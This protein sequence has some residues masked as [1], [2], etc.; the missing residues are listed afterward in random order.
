MTRKEGS[1]LTSINEIKEKYEPEIMEIPGVTGIGIG[2]N[3]PKTGLAIKVYVERI[4]PDLRVQIPA[5]L[6]GYPVI[7]EETGELGAF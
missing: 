2:S 5:E 7:A 6:E 4:T 3:D 1:K